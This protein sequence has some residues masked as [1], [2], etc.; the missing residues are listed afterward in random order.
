MEEAR[1]EDPDN[2]NEEEWAFQFNERNPEIIIPEEPVKDLDLDYDG[3]Q[4]DDHDDPEFDEAN[5]NQQDD[6][7][8]HQDSVKDGDN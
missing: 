2:F 7:Q 5:K 1:V 4:P 6:Q 3:T 8:D